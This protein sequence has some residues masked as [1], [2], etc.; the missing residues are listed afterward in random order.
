VITE[1]LE[2]V[3]RL[4]LVTKKQLRKKLMQEDWLAVIEMEDIEHM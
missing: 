4:D 3:L 2:E 1:D